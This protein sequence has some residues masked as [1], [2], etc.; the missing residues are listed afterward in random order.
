ME[1]DKSAAMKEFKVMEIA[2]EHEMEMN[3]EL[4]KCMKK[5]K[6]TIEKNTKKCWARGVDDVEKKLG[7]TNP[8]LDPSLFE[9]NYA[10]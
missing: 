4:S 7:I 10:I 6:N 5:A 3:A 1:N 2:L 9:E 8:P